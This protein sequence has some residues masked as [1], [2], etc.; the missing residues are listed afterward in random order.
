MEKDIQLGSVGD[1][2]LSL[3]GGKVKV[4]VS[5]KIDGAATEAGASVVVDGAVLI[6]KLKALVESKSPAALQGIE[7]GAFDM[8]KA[9][10]AS[11]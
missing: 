6:D 1:L 3:V 8:L 2:D 4:A 11:A 5:V 9:A 10:L 7:E